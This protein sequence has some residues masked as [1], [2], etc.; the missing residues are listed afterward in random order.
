MDSHGAS[1]ILCYLSRTAFI[2]TDPE[3]GQPRVAQ[4]VWV[5]GAPFLELLR[6]LREPSPEK[7]YKGGSQ[8][9]TLLLPPEFFLLPSPRDRARSVLTYHANGSVCR[10]R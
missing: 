3:F 5:G 9:K 8:E 7:F 2:G 10:A 4:G 1:V 6:V